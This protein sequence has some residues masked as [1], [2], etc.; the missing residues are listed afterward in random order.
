MKKLG[1]SELTLFSEV[2][3][4]ALIS[5]CEI[6][7]AAA[8]SSLSFPVSLGDA[9]MTTSSMSITFVVSRGCVSVF[10]A[11]LAVAIRQAVVNRMLFLI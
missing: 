4:L 7:D 8:G 1:T 3:C 11:R 5:F 6:S 9:M 2:I 10:S